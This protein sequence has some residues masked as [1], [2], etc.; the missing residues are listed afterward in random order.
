MNPVAL[1]LFLAG[2]GFALPVLTRWN[3]LPAK[4]KAHALTGHQF[5]IMLAAVGWLVR[6][7]AL[8]A[9]VH[10]AWLIVARFTLGRQLR[11]TKSGT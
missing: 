11:H 6:G 10:I 7:R 2:Y 4:Y 3:R 9:G 8:I 1:A 5:G